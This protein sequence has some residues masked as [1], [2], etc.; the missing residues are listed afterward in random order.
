MAGINHT[1][2]NLFLD[3]F[4]HGFPNIHPDKLEN[5]VPL[6]YTCHENIIVSMNAYGLLNM[7]T[8]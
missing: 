8:Q 6:S 5:K 3:N 4:H 2:D 1:E 7:F